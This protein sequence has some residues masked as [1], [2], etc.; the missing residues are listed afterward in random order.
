[1]SDHH[2]LVAQLELMLNKASRSLTAAQKLLQEG[3]HD[4]ASSRSYYAVFYGMQAVLLTKNLSASKH[5]GVIRLFNQHFIK[6]GTFPAEFSKFI[7]LLFRDRQIGDYRFDVTIAL[8][9][10][11]QD[12]VTAE[13]I[14]QAIT[15]YLI[16]EGL[17]PAP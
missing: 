1:M 4:F 6:N 16:K 2:D 7:N 5:A 3:D 9:R 14:V 15:A 11:Q 12:I 17:L 13:T 8:E 10:S